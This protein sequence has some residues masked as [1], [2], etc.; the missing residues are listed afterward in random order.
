MDD[1]INTPVSTS[2]VVDVAASAPVLNLNSPD[3]SQGYH[4]S[5]L[6]EVDIRDSIDYDG[7]SF[8]FNLTSDISGSILSESNPLE[9]HEIYLTAGEHTLT[10]T[11]TDDTGLSR[12]ESVS[13]LVVESDP[14]AVVYEPT[15]NQFYEPGELI[16]FDSNGTNDADNDITR[17]E[18]RL[19]VPGD[20][21][22]AVLS[23]A[24]FY[25]T[26]LLPGVHHVSLFVEDRR[27]GVDE[28]HLNITVASSSPDLSNLSASPKFILVDELTKVKV[29]VSLDDPD[30]TTTL[31]NATITKNLQSWTF[32]LTDENNDGIWEGEIEISSQESGKAQ[33]KVTAID[34]ELIDYMTMDLD[35]IEEET[36][37]SSLF[38]AAG[39]I[40][41][42]LLVS[43]LVAWL[44]IRRRKRL[45]DIDLID[46]WGVF[47]GETKEYIEDELEN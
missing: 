2:V 27:G 18:W 46:S 32:N 8:T 19:Y 43:S 37:Y 22:P 28:V 13:L 26:N 9:I 15:N 35:F 12:V 17:R 16:I 45:A 10:F 1:G 6:I 30:G 14:Q 44:V 7:D 38:I 39:G 23:N 21:Y 41:T 4:S 24:A 33:L 25:S 3:I 36:D 47:G 42:F 40:A 5:D 20:L 31:I 11:L 29:S 34:G